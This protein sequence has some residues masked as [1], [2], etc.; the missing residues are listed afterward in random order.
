MSGRLGV[1]AV[2]ISVNFPKPLPLFWHRNTLLS[3]LNYSLPLKDFTWGKE[4]TSGKGI[5][6]ESNVGEPPK[7]PSPFHEYN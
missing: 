6:T 2:T 1:G 4:N 7:M 5:K 3:I